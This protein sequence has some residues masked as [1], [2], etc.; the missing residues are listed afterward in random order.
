MTYSI[1]FRAPRLN[2]MLSRWVDAGLPLVDP[3][4]LYRD[5]LAAGAPGEIRR[6]TLVAAT[7]QL[8]ELLAALSPGADWFGEMVTETRTLEFA[9][10]EGRLPETV[11]IDPACR[12]AWYDA[13]ESITVY[14]NGE[15]LEPSGPAM[16]LG[17]L[18][19]GAA[20]NTAD[21]HDAAGLLETLWERGCLRD[22]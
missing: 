20:V 1:G 19:A 3:E 15:R 13:G 16:L 18:C 6:E 11:E 5:R 17:E 8:H 21:W 2:D 14:A 7:A 22:A 12:L 10:P 9:E 4:M